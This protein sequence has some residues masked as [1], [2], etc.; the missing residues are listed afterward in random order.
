MTEKTLLDDIAETIE[1]EF[2]AR[3]QDGMFI[4]EPAEA[5]IAMLAAMAARNEAETRAWE[6][7]DE[8]ARQLEKTKHENAR[9]REILEGL[10]ILLTELG[11]ESRADEVERALWPVV[12]VLEDGTEV[13]FEYGE[14]DEDITCEYC[15]RGWAC[16]C[17]GAQ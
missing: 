15:A 8:L 4:V 10:S 17:G 6:A 11:Y 2:N 16:D 13:E 5:G 12:G 14:T 1:Q 7:S 9:Y 3:I